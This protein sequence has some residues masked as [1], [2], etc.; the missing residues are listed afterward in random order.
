MIMR[1]QVCVVLLLAAAIAQ[2]AGSRSWAADN[3]KGTYSNP[4]FYDEFSDSDMIR[5]GPD[6][7]LTGTTM[8]AMPGWISGLT[9]HTKQEPSLRSGAGPGWSAAIGSL[10]IVRR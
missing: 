8:R 3:G 1:S 6:Y 5:V 2:G 7:Y 10:V 4:L 9:C